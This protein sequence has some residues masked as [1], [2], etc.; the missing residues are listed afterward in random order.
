MGQFLT[1]LHCSLSLTWFTAKHILQ[2][3]IS[4]L[5]IDNP[6]CHHRPLSITVREHI[7]PLKVIVMEC[8]VTLSV[9]PNALKVAVL[10][11]SSINIDLAYH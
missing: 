7:E 11:H 6:E 10:I 1:D 5:S 8:I 2:R 3:E 4:V 9:L